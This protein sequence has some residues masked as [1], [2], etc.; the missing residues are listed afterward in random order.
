MVLA[1]IGPRK[2]DGIGE[3]NGVC[4]PSESELHAMVWNVWS[5]YYD[6]NECHSL[7]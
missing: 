6:W 5:F 2:L 1:P 4:E 3:L 7:T